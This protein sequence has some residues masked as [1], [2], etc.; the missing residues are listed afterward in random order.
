MHEI[1]LIKKIEREGRPKTEADKE[2]AGWQ[3]LPAPSKEGQRI[4]LRFL[5]YKFGL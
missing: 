1:D 5:R 4:G 2:L 3:T